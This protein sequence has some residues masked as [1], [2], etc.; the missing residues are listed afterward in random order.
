MTSTFSRSDHQALIAGH[1]QKQGA[2][3]EKISAKEIVTP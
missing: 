3:S 1:A 2:T